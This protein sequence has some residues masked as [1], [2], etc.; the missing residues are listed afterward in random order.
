MQGFYIKYFPVFDILLKLLDQ[1]F[2]F[3]HNLRNITFMMKEYVF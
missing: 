3:P 2:N 1:N